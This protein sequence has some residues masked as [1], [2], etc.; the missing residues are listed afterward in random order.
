MGQVKESCM[1]WE[2]QSDNEI[3]RENLPAMSMTGELQVKKTE[4][5]LVYDRH[6]LEKKGKP[7]WGKAREEIPFRNVSQEAEVL[8]RWVVNTRNVKDPGN[9]DCFSSEHCKSCVFGKK[10]C[11]IKTGKE[12]M[13]TSYCKFAILRSNPLQEFCESPEVID[14]SIHEI[15]G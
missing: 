8:S 4:G 15:P 5:I 10:E 14:L 1:S 6:M 2:K 3:E 9:G 12:F 13:I 11:L 7:V